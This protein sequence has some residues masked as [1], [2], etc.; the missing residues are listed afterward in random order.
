[1]PTISYFYGI[2]IRIY[3]EDHNP[4]H[5]HV[6]YNNFEASVEIESGLI[7]AGKLPPK[8]RALTEEWRLMH[9]KELFVAWDLMIKYHQV[10]KIPGLK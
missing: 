6:K 4:P 2:Y 10:K 7:T 3:A 1:M 9:Q 5:F 8:A